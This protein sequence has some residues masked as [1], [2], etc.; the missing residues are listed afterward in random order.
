V[1]VTLDPTEIFYA[2]MVGV[3]RQVEALRF[4]SADAH[5]YS[6]EHP[7]QVHVEGA[8]GECAFAKA[9][10]QYWG[11]TVNTFKVGG[12]VGRL[13]VR[14]RSKSH[15][16]LLIREDDRDDDWFVLVT[17]QAPTYVIRGGCFGR[18]AKQEKYRQAYGAREP[19]YFVPQKDLTPF[20]RGS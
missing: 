11:R 12:D 14:T 10:G 4:G 18:F 9:S 5:G 1:V 17:G 7:W 3:Q 15:Y 8:L 13:Q 6:G 16:D 20:N 19:A 2:G